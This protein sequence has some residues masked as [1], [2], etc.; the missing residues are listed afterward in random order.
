[1]WSLS[2]LSQADSDPSLSKTPELAEEDVGSVLETDV[3]S[4]AFAVAVAITEP[5]G[6]VN[7]RD[8]CNVGVVAGVVAFIEEPGGLVNVRDHR[9]AICTTIDCEAVPIGRYVVVLLCL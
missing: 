8:S 4:D 2:R 9:N 3:V 7:V 6:A 5:G 1:M